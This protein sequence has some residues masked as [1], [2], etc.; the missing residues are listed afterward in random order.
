MP[1][2]SQTDL[3]S[4]VTKYILYVRRVLTESCLSGTKKRAAQVNLYEKVK[5]GK[6]VCSSSRSDLIAW[7]MC[8]LCARFRSRNAMKDDGLQH[9]LNG[10]KEKI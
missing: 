1:T 8:G 10:S 7:R 2:I 9:N 3:L 4:E 6:T 5:Y